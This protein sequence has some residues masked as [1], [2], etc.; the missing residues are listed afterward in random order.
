MNQQLYICQD[1]DS[2]HVP[3]PIGFSASIAKTGDFISST[4]WSVENWHEF[5][6]LSARVVRLAIELEQIKRGS[7]ELEESILIKGKVDAGEDI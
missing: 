7:V 2:C 3:D 5:Y 1:S 4:I 6:K